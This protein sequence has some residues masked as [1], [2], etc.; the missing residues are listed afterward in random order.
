MKAAKENLMWRGSLNDMEKIKLGISSCLLGNP[1][2]YDGGHKLDTF[3]KDIVGKYVEFVP[4]CPEV[5]MGLPVPRE[6]MHLVGYKENPRL[7]TIKTKLDYT[8]RMIEYAKNKVK[9]LK[10]ED[11]CGFVFKSK[12]PSSGYRNVKVYDENGTPHYTSAGLF[13]KVFMNENPLIPVEDEGRLKDDELRD[14]FFTRVFVYHNWMKLIKECLTKKSFI[15]FHT[16]NKLLLMAHSPKHY[17][18]LGRELSNLKDKKLS[19]FSKIYIKT[20]MEALKHRATRNK[21]VNVL[22]HIAGYFKKHLDSEEKKELIYLIEEYKKGHLPLIVPVTMINH[23]VR[24]F[25]IEYLKNQ[26]FLNPHPLE[27]KLKNY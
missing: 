1:V 16:S 20:I 19:D 7:I 5:E 11:L 23:Y 4:V 14:N 25:N 24:K 2:R 6:S 17:Q 8:D 26:T 15:D 13:A 9:E 27:L 12:S 3:L 10:K 18:A 22:F 21:K